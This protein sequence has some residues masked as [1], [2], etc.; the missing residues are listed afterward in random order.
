MKNIKL[1]KTI[2]AV[3]DMAVNLSTLK[4]ILQDYYDVCLSKSAKDALKI[5][6]HSQI[7]LIL[8]DIEMPEM[9]G[10]QFFSQLQADPVA[11]CIPVIFV[12]A[13]V[14]SAVVKQV[15]SMGA[16]D[17]IVKPYNSD[18]L[19]DKIEAAFSSLKV[20]P[21]TLF[22]TNQLSQLEKLCSYNDRPQAEMLLQA[23]PHTNYVSNITIA[24]TR[25]SLM[26]RNNNFPQAVKRVH[27]FAQYLK[28]EQ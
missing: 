27:E 2:L 24:L 3:D 1:R 26:I 21:A 12:T 20:D 19:L 22:L 7:D 17:Y 4:A 18:T 14:A 25:I 11:N 8:L 9:S 10:I 15:A 23:I 16:K 6:E 5:I 13:S 28:G